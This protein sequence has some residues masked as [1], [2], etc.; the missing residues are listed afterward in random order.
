[1][2]QARALGPRLVGNTSQRY[3]MYDSIGHLLLARSIGNAA[4]I[5]TANQQVVSLLQTRTAFKQEQ[6]SRTCI[7]KRG[8][9]EGGCI[10]AI[11]T[12]AMGWECLRLRAFAR[13]YLSPPGR[14]ANTGFSLHLYLLST[15][16]VTGPFGEA[17][18][19]VI[20]EPRLS[21]DALKHSIRE[22][23]DVLAADVAW[24]CQYEVR[25][26]QALS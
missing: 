22:F 12:S 21:G 11:L 15:L 6:R 18:G 25:R 24:E 23:Q 26:L 4:V 13:L 3:P 10:E 5:G 19:E 16:R 17:H 7:C 1:M 20:M 9:R 8:Y 2:G 14:G